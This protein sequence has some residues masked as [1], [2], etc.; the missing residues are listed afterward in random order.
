MLLPATPA[1][2]DSPTYAGGVAKIL[3]E[4]CVT[5]HRPGQ[6]G[7]FSLIGYENAKK[8]AK[9]IASV[10]KAGVMPPWKAISGYGAF[11][12]ENRLSPADILLLKNWADRGAPR[13]ATNKTIETPQFSSEWTLGKPD[14]VVTPSKAYS[15]PAEG[16][17]E[18]RNFVF[19]TNYSETRW[20]RAIDVRPG[21]NKVVHHVIAYLDNGTAAARLAAKST[22]GKEGYLAPGGGT[23]FMP[24]GALGGWA[25]GVRARNAPEGTAFR[26]EPGET[27]VMQI[28][29]HKSGKTELDQTKRAIYF[30]SEAPKRE[31]NLDWALN[32]NLSIPPGEANHK[33]RLERVI[34]KNATLYSTMPHMHLL[35]RNMKSWFEFADGTTQPLIDVE[36]WDFNWQLVYW[37]KTPIKL[38]AGTKHII[39]ATYDNSINNPRNP[40]NPPKRVTWGEQTTDEMFLLLSVY[41]LDREPQET[42]NHA[43]MLGLPSVRFKKPSGSGK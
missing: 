2:L 34:P 43:F 24:A 15:L 32:Y 33:V 11:L 22:D 38:P 29:Y 27:I 19:K 41:A 16:E 4:R 37:L 26:L 12:D 39:E 14:F 23:G 21:N 36:N 17:D 3:N 6:V 35:G 5:C 31:L 20:I 18:Y 42:P 1:H 28:H 10:T 7:P 13:G 40:N 30:A 9:T 25:P 8:Y